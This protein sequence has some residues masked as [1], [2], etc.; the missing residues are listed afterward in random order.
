MMIRIFLN[1]AVFLAAIVA[2]NVF[3]G[4]TDDNNDPSWMMVPKEAT[5]AD[6]SDHDDELYY[7]PWEEVEV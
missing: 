7:E 4:N 1:S 5:P 2:I 3:A 6:D